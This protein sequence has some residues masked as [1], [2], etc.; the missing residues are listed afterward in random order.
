MGLTKPWAIG[1]VILCTAF[2]ST[3]ALFLKMGLDRFSPTL[4][5]AL[6]AYPVLIGLF[7]YFLGFILLTI[8]FRYGELSTLFP[9]VSLSFIWVAITSYIF[10]HETI[11]PIECLGV[12]AIVAGVVMIGIS[13]R[14]PKKLRLKA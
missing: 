14:E 5:G 2:T 9:F 3:G 10:L 7:F 13:S 8:S 4:Q 6:D 12:A 1:L 11:T